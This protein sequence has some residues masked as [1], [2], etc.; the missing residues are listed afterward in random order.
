[1]ETAQNGKIWRR[2]PVADSPA[3][4]VLERCEWDSVNC[5]HSPGRETHIAVFLQRH[6]DQEKGG[7]ESV[8]V[9]IAYKTFHPASVPFKRRYEC[10]GGS[11]EEH[12]DSE[13]FQLM[14]GGQSGKQMRSALVPDGVRV[15]RGPNG[16]EVNAEITFGETDLPLGKSNPVKF[17][18]AYSEGEELVCSCC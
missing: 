7:E 4:R 15:E 6:P 5:W 14:A 8:K 9:K 2:K 18:V 13:G 16:A 3:E 12:D 11:L 10:F 17:S 1:M